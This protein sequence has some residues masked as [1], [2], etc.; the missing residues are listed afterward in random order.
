[1]DSRERA[2][3]FIKI[4]KL[5]GKW[6]HENH[7]P[8]VFNNKIIVTAILASLTAKIQLKYMYLLLMTR[9]QSLVE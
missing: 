4:L 9:N 6:Y 8:H 5:H 3:T 1:M 7:V 2:Y